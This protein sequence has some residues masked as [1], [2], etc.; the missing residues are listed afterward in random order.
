MP[1]NCRGH[2]RKVSFN[3]PPQSPPD[4]IEVTDPTHP[5]FGRR[6][7][8][9]SIT[10]QPRSTAFVFVAYRNAM[11]LRIPVSS[12]SLA[13][14]Q[15]PPPRTKWTQDAI[16]EL[17][18]LVQEGETPCRNHR[19]SGKRSRKRANSKSSTT[20]RRSARR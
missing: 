13:V 10:R 11:R 17:L 4:E 18:S 14:N 20:S 15:I 2:L 16:R 3:N 19:K 9:L 12:T 8:V 1:G 7:S 6:F 5:L